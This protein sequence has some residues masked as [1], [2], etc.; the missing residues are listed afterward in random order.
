MAGQRKP[1]NQPSKVPT[2][3]LA[4]GS[5]AGAVTV[6][7]VWILGLLHVPVPPEVASALTVLFS[8]ITSYSVPQRVSTAADSVTTE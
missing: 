1:V 8:F 4:A 7:V 2:T 6:V 5:T 3:K